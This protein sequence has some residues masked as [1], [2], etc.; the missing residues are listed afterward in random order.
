MN[1][2][3]LK[4]HIAT[5]KKWT[6]S[7]SEQAHQ[8]QI[9]R[10]SLSLEYQAYTKE[11]MLGMTEEDIYEY[12][13]PL[14]AMLLW[15]NKKYVIDKLIAN[16]GLEQLRKQLANLVW[17]TDKLENRWNEFRKKIKGMVPA[18]MSEL[19]CKTHPNDCALWNRRAL[20]AF[21]YL[22]IYSL[23]RYDYQFNGK[24]YSYLC[25]QAKSIAKIM[26]E[27]QIPAVD[28]L[29]V[30]YFIWQE[31]QVQDN[32]SKIS[33][34]EIS[35]AAEQVKPIPAKEAEFIHNDI[36]DK[37]AEI[38]RWLGFNTEIEK[39]VAD[40]AVVDAVWEV[41]IGNM[42]RVIYVFEVQTSGSIDSLLLNLMKAKNNKAVQGIVAVTD[43]KQIEKIKRESGALNQQ[44][45]GEL[46]FWD[47]QEVLKIHESLQYVNESINNLGLVPFGL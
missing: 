28:L 15:G 34:N 12:I 24:M 2:Q 17:G 16:N 5:Y 6:R 23:P 44:F 3:L 36:R 40:G 14:W 35:K 26:N 25:E 31:L 47:Y 11:R 32:L 43:Q 4:Q 30:D 22:E 42:G 33:F 9:E 27:E 45:N 1:I 10:R 41:I 37:L 39:K 19:L 29:T 38:G 8:E 21:N 46:K 7:N 18:M 20:V 13:A